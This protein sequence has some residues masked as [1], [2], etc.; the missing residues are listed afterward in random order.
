MDDP[1]GGAEKVDNDKYSHTYFKN[2]VPVPV[3]LRFACIIGAKS[4]A[5]SAAAVL[6]AYMAM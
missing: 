3:E 4:L 1:D 5:A 6:G 2:N